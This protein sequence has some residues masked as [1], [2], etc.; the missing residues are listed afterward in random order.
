[1]IEIRDLTK[2]FGPVL[3][4]DR[5]SFTVPAGTVTGFL[6]PN[7]AG[8][9]T[10]LRCLLGLVAPS[11]GKALIGGRRYADLEDPAG[12]VGAVLE[13]SGANPGRS[14][15]D[16]LRVL[17]LAAGRDPRR[18]DELLA[19]VGLTDA[20]RRRVVGYSMG[21]RQRLALAAALL[22]QPRALVLD[23]PANGLD[24]EGVRWLRSLL[25]GFADGGGTV[26]VSSHVL[27]EI[28]VV[29]DEVVLLAQGRLVT[30]S[31]VAALADAQPRQAWVRS[32][33]RDRLAAALAEQGIG[34]RPADPDGLI[35]DT[36]A[37]AVGELAA[38]QGVVLHELAERT[39]TLEE[40]FFRLT[41]GSPGAQVGGEVAS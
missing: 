37:V 38:S 33:G 1:M 40:L 21:M 8:K 25:R 15:R 41:D 39:A 18:I 36:S 29:A 24:P 27:A 9:T 28:A 16:H 20:A 30:Q 35:A 31:T 32:P 14:G 34:V 17:A 10:T 2:R 11:G 23:E 19:M 3:A 22:G 13:G 5:L 26:L 12:T 6:G 4:V 7:G